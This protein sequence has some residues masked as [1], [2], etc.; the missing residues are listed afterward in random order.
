MI[1]AR[2]DGYRPTLFRS[3]DGLALGLDE[4]RAEAGL[5]LRGGN[6]ALGT[7]RSEEPF[8]DGIQIGRAWRNL[9][10]R[11][12]RTVV[13]GSESPPELV[14]VVGNQIPGA[15]ARWHGLS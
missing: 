4:Q 6:E 14:V 10:D 5:G 11:D 2:P 13:S 15:V 1:R 9:R 8:T 3:C 12:T 7:H